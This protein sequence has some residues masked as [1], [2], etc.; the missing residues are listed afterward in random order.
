MP[1]KKKVPVK[2]KGKNVRISDDAHAQLSNYCKKQGYNLGTFLANS[3]L[4]RMQKE[5]IKNS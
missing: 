2:L 4:A 1:Q 3:A 5:V